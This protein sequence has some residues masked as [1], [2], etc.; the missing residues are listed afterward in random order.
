M[1]K[2]PKLFPRRSFM[3]LDDSFNGFQSP[4]PFAFIVIGCLAVM[5]G[6]EAFTGILGIGQ[7]AAADV[8]FN[9]DGEA[10]SVWLFLQ[11]LIALAEL[12]IYILTVIFFLIW[13]NRSNK[14]LTPL[15]AKNAEFTSGW[16]VGWWF[17]PFANLVK[18]FQVVR[19]VWCES[20]P[21]S[22]DEPVFLS[23]S[24]RS[25]PTYMGVWWGFWLASNILS[26]I[27][28]RTLEADT[29]GEIQFAGVM[30]VLSGFATL[31]AAGLAC[32]VVWDIT[33]R[34]EARIA[35]IRSAETFDRSNTPEFGLGI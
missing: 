35:N 28:S 34:Q 1:A 4:K 15:R 9:V 16:A 8:T 32:W 30:F 17:I 21:V 19:E 20:D 13:L 26:N 14:N 18:P 2:D 31:I 27:A 29:A 22:D 7:F 23:A 24:L 25:A 5:G 12:P 33:R 10:N 6:L 11:G 3:T